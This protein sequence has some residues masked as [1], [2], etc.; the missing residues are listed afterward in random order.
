MTERERIQLNLRFDKHKDLYS[1]VR[2]AAKEQGIS[3]NDFVVNALQGVLGWE[4]K[5]N[6][7]SP[8][9]MQQLEERLEE[10][11]VHRLVELVDERIEQALARQE[12]EPGEI[13]A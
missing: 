2:Q 12:I 1:A 6:T 7:P 8:E 11:L 5:G 3:I 10:R 4:I 9:A 13:A